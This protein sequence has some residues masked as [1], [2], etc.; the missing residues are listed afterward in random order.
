[1]ENREERQ[2]RGEPGG[3]RPQRFWFQPETLDE[4]QHEATRL[5]RTP[6]W[7]MRQA[8]HLAKGKLAQLPSIAALEVQTGL[9][10]IVAYQK[11]KTNEQEPLHH[12]DP[13]A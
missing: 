1:M 8:W 4:I 10:P 5:G 6:S 7:V 12:D 3:T 9:T 2:Y 13:D 11:E